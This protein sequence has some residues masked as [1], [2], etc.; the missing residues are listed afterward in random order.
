VN[1]VLERRPQASF[2]VVAV[3]PNRGTPAQVALNSNKSKRNAQAVLRSLTD[4]GM[5][6]S[7]VHA[8]DATSASVS[9]NEVH[10]FVR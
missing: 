8:S 10:V 2:D 9:S 5:P 1:R 6:S 4:M 7:R 3:T